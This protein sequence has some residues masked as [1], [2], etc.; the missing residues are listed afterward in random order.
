MESESPSSPT[1][2]QFSEEIRVSAPNTRRRVELTQR[3]DREAVQKR[4]DIEKWMD[5]QMK[6]LFDCNV[7]RV[8]CSN[9]EKVQIAICLKI[10]LLSSTVSR[11]C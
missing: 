8:Y 10:K 6:V 9:I 2:V 4:L 7:S 3:Y 1:R 11:Y 5:E